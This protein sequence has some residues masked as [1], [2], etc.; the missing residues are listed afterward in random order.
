MAIRVIIAQIPA[1]PIA[2]AGLCQLITANAL[3]SVV[4]TASSKDET[5]HLA[6]EERP[7]VLLLDVL[8]CDDA[9]LE[10]IA[11]LAITIHGSR[12]ILLTTS[13]SLLDQRR[14]VSVGAIG[15]VRQNE[16]PEVLFKAMERVHAGE[17]WLERSLVAKVLHEKA[18]SSTASPTNVQLKVGTLTEREHEVIAFVCQGA[19]NQAIA[20]RLFVSEATVRHRLTSIFEKLQLSD[21]L[22]LVIFA[23]QHGLAELPQLD[24]LSARKS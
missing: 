18:L 22:E 5:L 3:F 15:L 21:R 8:E 13:I 19:K 12:I 11:E 24:G 17:I 9:M 20:E 14:A 23:F 10:L 7:D 16:T 1:R 4:G 2:L 6:S